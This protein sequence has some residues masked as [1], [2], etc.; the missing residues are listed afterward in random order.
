[1]LGRHFLSGG[2]LFS[3]D[4]SSCQVETKTSQ[5]TESVGFACLRPCVFGPVR[6]WSPQES[7]AVFI[8]NK[9]S[10]SVGKKN[11]VLCLVK[12]R[13]SVN[14][15]S[16]N[17]LCH[18]SSHTSH[19]QFYQRIASAYLPRVLTGCRLGVIILRERDLGGSTLAA[20]GSRPR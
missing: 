16:L 19:S 12:K 8:V 18:A 3:G 9:L 20:D 10:P 17:F 5:H 2:S 1:M 13:C 15:P 14:V 4:C 6:L 11:P 7:T